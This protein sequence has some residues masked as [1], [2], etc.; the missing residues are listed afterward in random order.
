MPKDDL[1]RAFQQL[2]DLKK[3]V[4]YVGCDGKTMLISDDNNALVVGIP[5]D[6]KLTNDKI[7][8]KTD[9]VLKALKTMEDNIMVDVCAQ[10]MVLS[11]DV[12][13]FIISRDE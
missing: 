4:A 11:D 2:H 13:C 10:Y 12:G 6:N 1:Q 8:V 3:P 9:T 5:V 7:Q